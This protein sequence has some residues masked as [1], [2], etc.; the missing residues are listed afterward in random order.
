MF[1]AGMA[2]F[3]KEKGINYSDITGFCMEVKKHL[4]RGCMHIIK[5]ERK[6]IPSP[7][8]QFYQCICGVFMMVT[9]CNKSFGTGFCTDHSLDR[10]F[11][12]FFP[13]SFLSVAE[14]L[15]ALISLARLSHQTETLCSFCRGCQTAIKEALLLQ[16][17]S[18]CLFPT[19]A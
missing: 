16:G 13:F 11:S 18:G 5:K 7:L 6:K 8:P 10:A 17:T 14:V 12:F 4:H 3:W 2:Y 1:Y 9:C 15:Y 19:G